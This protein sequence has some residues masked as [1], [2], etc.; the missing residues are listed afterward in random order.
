MLTLAKVTSFLILVVSILVVVFGSLPSGLATGL[1]GSSS[2]VLAGALVAEE[3]LKKYDP[4]LLAKL[5]A[6]LSV[7]RSTLAEL[8]PLVKSLEGVGGEVGKIATGVE[9]LIAS[10]APAPKPAAKTAAKKS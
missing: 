8:S 1:I 7:V 10:L 9:A 5:A 3:I 6:D 4:A 2:V